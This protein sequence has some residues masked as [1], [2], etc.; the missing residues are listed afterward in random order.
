MLRRITN[1]SHDRRRRSQYQRARTEHN[2]DRHRTDDLTG[3]CPRK[4][5][6][7]QR[8]HYDPCRPAVCK[9]YDL[10]LARIRR[11][12]Q[13]YHTLQGTVLPHAGRFHLKRTKLIDR[14]GENIISD[15]L[16]HR[17][18]FSRH[19]RLID[20]RCSRKDH[21]V[22][23]NCLTRKYPEHIVK[24]NLFRLDDLLPAIH[25]PSC[26]LRCQLH[27]LLNTGSGLCHR[28]LLQKGTQLHDQRHLS[29]S[30]NFSN[31]D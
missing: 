23:R 2:K 31:T 20:R 26:R 11:L 3:H 14:T 5:S 19:D 15:R 13:T 29:G 24:R 16:I 18:R 7:R 27:Q 25:Q 9:P 6:C 30:K 28:Q 8:D 1:T 21:T 22:H 10:C 17:K 12:N 4:H